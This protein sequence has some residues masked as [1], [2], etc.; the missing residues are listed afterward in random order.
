MEKFKICPVCG[1]KNP[2]VLLECQSCE[3]DLSMVPVGEEPIPEPIP[4]PVRMVRVCEECGTA[5]PAQ[6]RVCQNCGEDLTTV[7]LTPEGQ[8]RFV[9]ADLDGGFAWEVPE[10]GA[11]LGREQ[12]MADYLGGKA[13]VSRRHAE[14]TIREGSLLVKNLS[15]TNFTFR[16]N[17]RIESDD[18]VALEDGDLLGLGGIETELGR[19]R[20]AAYF[21]VRIGPCT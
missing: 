5:N 9:L 8:N 17:E 10:G 3:A 20:E 16:N 13:Y 19:Q 12:A 15:R 6:H 1:Q 4:E 21:R 18:F 2:P 11:I 14:L 7:R